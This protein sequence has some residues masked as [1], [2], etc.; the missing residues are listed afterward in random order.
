M[1]CEVD[2]YKGF[3]EPWL[4]SPPRAPVFACGQ[5]HRAKKAAATNSAYCTMRIMVLQCGTIYRC[6]HGFAEAPECAKVVEQVPML[7]KN[8]LALETKNGRSAKR[9]S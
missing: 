3:R 6:K 2:D 7:D 8:N 5:L 4:D 9:T 1:L